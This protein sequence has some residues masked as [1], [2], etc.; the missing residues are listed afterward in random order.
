MFYTLI[1]LMALYFIYQ[2]ELS[3]HIQNLQY[4]CAPGL[5]KYF[6]TQADL[7]FITFSNRTDPFI[8]TGE[9]FKADSR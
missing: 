6:M 8:W 2:K 1:V 5:G 7:K 4:L 9:I 3:E